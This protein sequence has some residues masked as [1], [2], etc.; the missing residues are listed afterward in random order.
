MVPE[1]KMMTGVSQGCGSA[2]IA[3]RA[4]P[5]SAEGGSMAWGRSS[6]LGP[7]AVRITRSSAGRLRPA[8]RGARSGWMIAI[9]APVLL[10]ACSSSR[11]R[12]LVLI[13][14]SAAPA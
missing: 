1:V 6:A 7:G 5:F 8:S 12:K 11:P 2:R 13:G 4:S 10:T 9:F 14:A 3:S